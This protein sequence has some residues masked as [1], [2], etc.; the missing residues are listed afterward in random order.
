MLL[1]VINESPELMLAH[2]LRVYTMIRCYRDECDDN[3][4]RKELVAKL[5]K[6][7]MPMKDPSLTGHLLHPQTAPKGVCKD[8][9]QSF[10]MSESKR[11]LVDAL[12]HSLPEHAEKDVRLLVRMFDSQKTFDLI[13]AMTP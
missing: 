13:I 7:N 6:M 11:N 2:R 1:D 4:T 5:E 8:T 10:H 9:M 3:K 12:K